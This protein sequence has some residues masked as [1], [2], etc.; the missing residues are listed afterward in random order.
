MAHAAAA[1]T[2]N[3][4]T[5]NS[6]SST[7]LPND[8]PATASTPKLPSITCRR[9]GKADQ[10]HQAHVGVTA[11]LPGLVCKLTARSRM[12]A[13]SRIGDLESL[14]GGRFEFS[15][16]ALW[17]SIGCSPIRLIATG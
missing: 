6:Q 11:S 3:P 12:A 14:R 13:L 7:T 9:K 5:T 1:T 16:E 15:L 10:S 8:V 17:L 4:L 2:A